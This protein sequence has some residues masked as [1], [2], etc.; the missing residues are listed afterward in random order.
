LHNPDLSLLRQWLLEYENPD[1]DEARIKRW[2]GIAWEVFERKALLLAAASDL[3]ANG[4]PNA[5]KLAAVDIFVEKAQRLLTMR[6]SLLYWAGTVTGVV[7][8]TLL[9]G[10]VWYTF[11]SDVFRLLGVKDADATVSSAVLTMAIL[12][13]TTAGGFVAAM[14]YFLVSLSRALLHEATVLYSR[15]HSLRFGRLYVYLLSSELSFEHLEK[16][17]NWNAEFTT[18]FKDI[19][20]GKM[21]SPI[22]KALDSLTEMAK[23]V[24][25][26][27]KK[28]SDSGNKS[29]KSE[30]PKHD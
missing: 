3:Q 21:G 20:A 7:A 23:N 6:G 1:V 24:N 28:A 4:I 19:D 15:R 5:L 2:K 14:V 12:K 30:E 26:V 17:F 16:A 8:V 22:S 10:S 13:T 25:A 29:K 27:A 18:A 11:N 9:G